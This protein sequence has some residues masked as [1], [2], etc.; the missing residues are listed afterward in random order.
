MTAMRIKVPL[1]Y[2]FPTSDEIYFLEGVNLTPLAPDQMLQLASLPYR[3][4][5]FLQLAYSVS[6]PTLRH[7]V[8][9]GF[10]D[11]IEQLDPD[12]S[13]ESRLISTSLIQSLV[14]TTNLRSPL[15]QVKEMK[16]L[17]GADFLGSY[18][19]YIIH[20]TLGFSGE[21]LQKVTS[22]IVQ[23]SLE[24]C[25]AFERLLIGLIQP[26]DSWQF[27]L[28]NIRMIPA[29]MKK[30]ASTVKAEIRLYDPTIFVQMITGELSPNDVPCQELE[31]IIKIAGSLE[32]FKPSNC[33]LK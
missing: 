29:L 13:N 18:G 26:D 16:W 14:I 28:V 5:H 23:Y 3:D 6:Y 25:N 30:G 17:K 9:E 21:L 32:H 24:S 19:M 1:E 33:V 22:K 31:S 7:Y 2:R 10:L 12:S 15:Y 8:D 4:D 11:L 27:V 20:S